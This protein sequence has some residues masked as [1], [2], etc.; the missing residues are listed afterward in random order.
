MRKWLI[1]ENSGIYSFDALLCE[2]NLGSFSIKSLFS[3]L[4][5]KAPATIARK[6][7]MFVRKKHT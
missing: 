1:Y 2:A 3:Q 4:S 7:R 6:G 5:V